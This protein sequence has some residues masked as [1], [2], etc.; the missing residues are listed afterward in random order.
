VTIIWLAGLA[1]AFA[2]PPADTAAVALQWHSMRAED[3]ARLHRDRGEGLHERGNWD[4]A[5]AELEQAAALAPADATA[6]YLLGKSYSSKA[7]AE[8]SAEPL[9]DKAIAHLIRATELQPEYVEALNELGTIYSAL[10]R[11][12]DA[13][14]VYRRALAIRPEAEAIHFNIADAYLDARQPERA[15]AEYEWVLHHPG[16]FAQ[17]L[18]RVHTGIGRALDQQSELEEAVAALTLALQMKPDYYPAHV[19]L[20]NVYFQQRKFTEAVAEYEAAIAAHPNDPTLDFTVSQFYAIQRNTAATL[21]WLER[22]FKK[23]FADK[24]AVKNNPLFRRVASDPR[25][26]EL[27]GK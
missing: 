2:S 18:Y 26:I 10:A 19:S 24:A 27:M 9:L 17:S 8:A 21:E 23:G 3:T 6:H 4:G 14:A 7:Y 11:T 22:A 16:G 1:L 15:L 5:I 12:A 20:G 25:F 13:I